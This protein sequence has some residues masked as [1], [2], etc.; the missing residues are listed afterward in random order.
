MLGIEKSS[1][2][3]T[4]QACI[5]TDPSLN[6]EVNT[7]VKLSCSIRDSLSKCNS[8]I[9]WLLADNLASY[10]KC[11]SDGVSRS[12]AR[13]NGTRVCY[14]N[15]WICSCCCGIRPS[16]HGKIPMLRRPVRMGWW[17]NGVHNGIFQVLRLDVSQ[18]LTICS[19]WW[20]LCLPS[21]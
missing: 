17:D 21:R 8:V 11:H 14:W 20:C 15:G 7:C 10:E 19:C 2:G 1:C 12:S 5:C 6:M 4:D 16:N 13:S 3:V 18:S 9:Y